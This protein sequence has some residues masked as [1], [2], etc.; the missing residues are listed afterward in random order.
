M[1]LEPTTNETILG[2]IIAALTSAQAWGFWQRKQ[3]ARAQRE[4]EERDDK[5]L[6]R[7]DLRKEVQ[8]LKEELKKSYK[9]KDEE[10]KKMQEQIVAL[11]KQ[12]SEFKIRVEFL[13]KE[14]TRLRESLTNSQ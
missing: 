12:L 13:E 5:N 8:N 4:K 3:Q 2:S 1:E 7:D 6:Y 14:N 11:T 10:F 9:E